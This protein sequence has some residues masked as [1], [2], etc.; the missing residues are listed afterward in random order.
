MVNVEI[1]VLGSFLHF[2]FVRH[3]L[4]TKSTSLYLHSYKTTVLA[5]QA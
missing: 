5:L 3:N 4:L 1:H 2:F